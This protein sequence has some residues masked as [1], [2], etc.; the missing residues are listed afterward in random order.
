MLRRH[1][2]MM[3]AGMAALASGIAG[4]SRRTFLL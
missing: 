1:F 3:A 2:L 4:A